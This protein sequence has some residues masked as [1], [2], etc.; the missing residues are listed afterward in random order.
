VR[1]PQ[2][3]RPSIWRPHGVGDPPAGDPQ[4]IG[5]VQLPRPSCNNGVHYEGGQNPPPGGPHGIGVCPVVGPHGA[6]HVG[7]GGRA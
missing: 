7:G 1:P 5:G 2:H 6:D 3:H 4:N